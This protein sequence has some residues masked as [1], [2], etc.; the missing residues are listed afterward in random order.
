MIEPNGWSITR[1]DDPNFHNPR[2]QRRIIDTHRPIVFVEN[3]H[4]VVLECGHSPL[5][6][7]VPDPRIGDT[8]FCPNCFSELGVS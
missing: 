5:V 1:S 4:D 2:F 8:I 6:F 3:M 7:C